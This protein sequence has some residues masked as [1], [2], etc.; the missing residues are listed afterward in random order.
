MD[1]ARERPEINLNP[2][3]R[4]GILTPE[5]KQALVEWG[6][7]YSVCDFCGGRLDMVQKPNIQEFIYKD[8]PE[9]LGCDVARTTNGAR[10]AMFAI[11][12][13][14]KDNGEYVLVDGNA[15]YTTLVS[16]ELSGLDVKM[17]DSSG[18]PEHKIDVENY[19]KFLQEEKP[20]LVVLTYPDGSYGNL[21]DAAKLAKIC[22]DF[23]V[24]FA[25]NGAYSVG[26]MPLSMT[27]LGADFI[28]GSGHKSM[29]AS[30]PI[31]VLGTTKEWSEKLFRI[32]ALAKNKEV[33][34][35]GCSSR[36][37]TLMT[38]IA[39]FPAVK[40]RIKRWDEEIEKARRFS[41]EME[42]L[43]MVQLGEKPHNHDLLN[44]ETNPFFRISEKHKKRGFF[45]HSA[46]KDRGIGGIKPGRT[47]S[48]KLSTYLLTDAEI[49]RVVNAFREIIEENK[50]LLE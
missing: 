25:I 2:I 31:G 46:L 36:G 15:H 9:F 50:G 49:D 17:V 16:A 27:E 32:S 37:A 35:L 3:Q 45:L 30:G 14:L 42:K 29:A 40:E 4:G 22:S 11:M 19:V 7:G 20:A 10:E 23:K 24:P 38:L 1:L 48:M 47:K 12:H 33:E 34:I 41:R 5:A 6:D 26:R 39:S 21:P 18:S 43:G 44:F 8:L 13:T 28:I